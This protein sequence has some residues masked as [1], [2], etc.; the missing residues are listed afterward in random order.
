MISNIY[1]FTHHGQR[2]H[3]IKLVFVVSSDDW[4]TVSELNSSELTAI[5][6]GCIGAKWRSS[7]IKEF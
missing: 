5:I 2:F 4:V 7:Y 1:G 6:Y 3:M